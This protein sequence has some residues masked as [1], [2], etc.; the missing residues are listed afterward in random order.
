LI[1][2]GIPAHD[3][4]RVLGVLLWKVRKVMAEFGRDYEIVV[5]DDASTDQTM[6]SLARY[7]ALLPLRV[8]RSEVQLGYAGA[9]ERI[10]RDV[11]DRSPY[12]KRDVLVILQGDFTEDPESLVPMV[13]AIE[14]G[15]DLVAGIP[16]DQ[17]ADLPFFTRFARRLAPVVLGRAHSSAPVTAPLS[18]YRAYRLIVPKKALRELDE[19]GELLTARGWGANLELLALLAPH[20]RRIEEVPVRVGLPYRQR[21]SRFQPLESLRL[22][23]GL[24]GTSWPAGGGAG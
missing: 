24:R 21:E 22:L 2:I 17:S 12:P 11:V 20:A 18:G 3:E 6:E 9:V 8:I 23:T 5:L 15:A 10:I 13:K 7:Q 4:A 1:Y 14:G 19:G 16:E